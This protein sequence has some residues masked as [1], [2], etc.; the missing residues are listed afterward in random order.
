MVA[1]DERSII[2][3][4]K[5]DS[6][7]KLARRESEAILM[8]SEGFGVDVVARLVGRV[9]GTVAQWVKDWN[10][11]HGLRNQVVGGGHGCDRAL[12]LQDLANDLLLELIG[13]LGSRHEL[14]PH[15]SRKE[16]LPKSEGSRSLQPSW[17]VCIRRED[18]GREH[19][20][21]FIKNCSGVG[22]V[23]FRE[24]AGSQGMGRSDGVGVVAAPTPPLN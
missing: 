13:A 1:D 24:R 8:P 15:L 12:L 22:P 7:Y 20:G 11:L 14:T 5:A 18:C 10:K 21:L 17:S 2:Q 19:V 4:H 9:A 16:T 23:V 3:W 6:P